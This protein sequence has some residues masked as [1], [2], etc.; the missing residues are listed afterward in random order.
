MSP[1]TRS[2]PTAAIATLV[3]LLATR[4]LDAACN[5]IPSASKTFRSALGDTNR[6]FAA[7]GD[8]VEV[9]AS[10]A[11]CAGASPGFSA[12]PDDHVVTVLFTPPANGPWAASPGSCVGPCSPHRNMGRS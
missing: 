11:R 1:L 8:F 2:G 3:T 4:P 9:G 6:P 5:L 10:P 7:P 12:L